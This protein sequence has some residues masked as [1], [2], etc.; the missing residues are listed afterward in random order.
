MSSWYWAVGAILL[1]NIAILILR[2][3][4]KLGGSL[5]MGDFFRVDIP[6]T[7]DQ[8]LAM[9]TRLDCAA[10]LK[11]AGVPKDELRKLIDGNHD[12][13]LLDRYWKLPQAPEQ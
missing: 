1:I 13:E 8:P 4:A 11:V 2:A 9:G 5:R 3:R 6:R 12:Q 10:V 7:A